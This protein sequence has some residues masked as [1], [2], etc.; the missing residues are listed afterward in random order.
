[1]S[2]PL[3]I[4]HMAHGRRGVTST[5]IRIRCM[6]PTGITSPADGGAP[7][8]STRR[9]VHP[10]SRFTSSAGS[11]RS[12]PRPESSRTAIPA[13][14]ATTSEQ[15]WEEWQVI[16][17]VPGRPSSHVGNRAVSGAWLARVRCCRDGTFPRS[18]G[19]SCDRPVLRLSGA[20]G[21]LTGFGGETA[22]RPPF[23]KRPLAHWKVV[24]SPCR[25]LDR[26]DAERP[27]PEAPDHSER[28]PDAACGT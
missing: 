26:C 10:E 18:S 28:P 5:R 16:P 13:S 3:T 2:M 4:R 11:A 9:G 22:G 27:F 1:M 23:R 25:T 12:G 15:V 24:E 7:W 20:S 8:T 17:S 6:S 14:V 19:C 21:S